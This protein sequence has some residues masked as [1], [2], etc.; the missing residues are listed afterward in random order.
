MAASTFVNLVRVYSN[1]AGTGPLVL[2]LAEP[3]FRGKEALTDGLTYSYT[4]QTGVDNANPGATAYETGRGVWTAATSTLTRNVIESSLNGQPIGVLMNSLISITVLAQDFSAV[5]AAALA[6]A[7]L[8]AQQS[9]AD[10][11]AD[12]AAAAGSAT[13]AAGSATTATTQA[14]M[15]TTQAGN[16]AISAATASGSATTAAGS[17]TA[18]AGSATAAAAS[19]ASAT[20]SSATAVSAATAAGNSAI[21]AASSATGAATSAA[22]ASTS[23]ASTSGAVTTTANNAA[24]AQAGAITAAQQAAIAL[25]AASNPSFAIQ[26]NPA[27]PTVPPSGVSSGATYWAV[28]TTSE[29]LVLYT[30]TAGTGALVTPILK[31]PTGVSLFSVSGLIQYSGQTFNVKMGL[32]DQ[33]LRRWMLC[34]D[35]GE[36]NLDLDSISSIKALSYG[37]VTTVSGINQLSAENAGGTYANGMAF[38]I[39]VLDSAGHALA[40]YLADGTFFIGKY[41]SRLSAAV[42][43]A[44]GPAASRNGPFYSAIAGQIVVYYGSNVL[45]LTSEGTNTEPRVLSDGVSFLSN[46]QRGSV[47]PYT[48]NFDGSNQRAMMDNAVYEGYPIAGQSQAPGYISTPALSLIALYPGKAL[49]YAGGAG[50]VAEYPATFGGSGTL[51]DL[52]EDAAAPFKGESIASSA[53]F[54]QLDRELANRPKLKVVAYGNGYPATA[55][56]GIMKGTGPYNDVIAQTT[57]LAAL[58]AIE[59]SAGRA[60]GIKRGAIARALYFIHGETDFANASYAANL[61]Q[62][63]SDYQADIQAVTLQ[64]EPV[65]MIITQLGSMRMWT[66]TPDAAGGNKSVLAQLAASV[67][68]PRIV[69]ACPTYQLSYVGDNIHYTNVS[70]RLIGEYFEKATRKFIFEG[71]DWVPV[72][73]KPFNTWTVNAGAG[74]I[75][76]PMNVPIGPLAFDTTLVTDPGNKGFSYVDSAGRTIANVQITGANS[77]QILITLSGP[78]ASTAVVNYAYSNGTNNTSGPVTGARGCLRDSDSSLSRWDGATHLYNWCVIFRQAIN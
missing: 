78:I 51:D 38:G 26:A 50:P 72:S 43:V 5:D 1:S 71:R 47:M 61:T 32:V 21:A 55:Y 19:A 64:S 65:P 39:S 33:N 36:V 2:G 70:K 14:G 28:D 37:G 17:A 54:A 15:A 44:E 46:R 67:A 22:S 35:T 68:N 7:V 20:G 53:M 10:A 40:G 11:D 74:T 75:L 41:D 6:A 45:A 30:N 4:L 49:M 56:V 69:L 27:T 9:A 63:Q 18:A 59:I 57:R 52:H 25:S 42:A 8:D 24:L 23:A 48:M 29:N 60:A 12:A 16:A 73:P 3:G 34:L 76:I 66:T 77:D 13:S 58:G 62:L 31:I